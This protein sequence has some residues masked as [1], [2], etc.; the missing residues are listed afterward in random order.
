MWTTPLELGHAATLAKEVLDLSHF[1]EHGPVD[2]ALKLFLVNFCQLST[3]LVDSIA[4]FLTIFD[5]FVSVGLVLTIFHDLLYIQYLWLRVM[6]MDIN[7]LARVI[8]L[9][10]NVRRL[11]G[12]FALSMRMKRFLMNKSK[13]ISQCLK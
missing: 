4:Q 8:T 5:K 13:L 12:D 7:L 3:L 9:A 1:V 10:M 2:N 11:A 6:L